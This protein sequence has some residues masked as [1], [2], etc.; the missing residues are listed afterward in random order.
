[1]SDGESD[2]DGG[3]GERLSK[4]HGRSSSSYLSLTDNA[5]SLGGA[6]DM[7]P[8]SSPDKDGELC[9]HFVPLKPSSAV[10]HVSMVMMMRL[11]GDLFQSSSEL[12]L[13]VAEEGES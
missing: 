10:L 7:S 1:M 13:D 6:L 3:S 11:T 9:V 12:D 2:L 8:L 4:L 5:Y